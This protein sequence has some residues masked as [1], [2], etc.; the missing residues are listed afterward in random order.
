MRFGH[1]TARASRRDAAASSLGSPLGV[2]ARHTNAAA[3]DVGERGRVWQLRDDG[4]PGCLADANLEDGCR[5]G[6]ESSGFSFRY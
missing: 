5:T 3:R 6:T 1:A 4:Q 2:S